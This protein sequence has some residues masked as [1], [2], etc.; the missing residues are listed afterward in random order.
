MR[1]VARSLNKDM[2]AWSSLGAYGIGTT[3]MV[4]VSLD[5]WAEIDAGKVSHYCELIDE[6]ATKLLSRKV[7]ND[8][9]S[10]SWRE[11]FG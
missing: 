2:Q 6:A 8:E 5:V 1:N 3:T 10:F 4:Q 9:T 7:S 11:G